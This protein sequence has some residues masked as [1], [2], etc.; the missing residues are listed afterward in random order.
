MAEPERFIFSFKEIAELM[1]RQLNLTE[2]VWGLYVRFGITAANVGAGPED[3]KPTALVPV[4][5][6]G[7]QKM[8]EESA[9]TVNIGRRSAPVKKA[10]PRRTTTKV[11]S[12]TSRR[13]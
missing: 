13:V 5:E 2:G 8:D 4:M 7:L 12:R 9:L 11:G 3:L 1:A 6:I 10:H